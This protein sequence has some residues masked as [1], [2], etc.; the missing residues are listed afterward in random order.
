[1]KYKK[2]NNYEKFIVFL[3]FTLLA[4]AVMATSVLHFME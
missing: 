3:K 2:E 1:M 4:M